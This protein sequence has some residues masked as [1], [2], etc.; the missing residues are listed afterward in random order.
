MACCNEI[1][2]VRLTDYPD[3]GH[4]V[5]PAISR[6]TGQFC[7]SALAQEQTQTAGLGPGAIAA[8]VIISLAVII[9][10]VLL[11]IW[12]VKRRRKTR[13]TYKPAEVEGQVRNG[14]I[15]MNRLANRGERVI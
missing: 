5:K 3:H 8:L 14:D 6:L 12:H 1:P 9:I 15:Y 7:E 10:I 2:T 11:I 4:N 13:G